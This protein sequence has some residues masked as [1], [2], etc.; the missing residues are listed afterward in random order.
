MGCFVKSRVEYASRQP[1]SAWNAH[2]ESSVFVLPHVSPRDLGDFCLGGLVALLQLAFLFTPPSLLVLY[3]TR[4]I[5]AAIVTLVSAAAP[6]GLT[7]VRGLDLS[8]EGI[9]F[10]RRFG[11][12]KLLRWNQ[13]T[14]IEPVSALEV[15]LRGSFWP[16]PPR[17]CC[18]TF[19]LRGHYRISWKGN[20]CYFPPADPDLF[21]RY[22]TSKISKAGG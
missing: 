12:P 21:E 13:I 19:T 18:A 3:A 16:I 11:S 8:A 5:F 9:R 10:R 1:R 20:Y 22:V 15:V 7:A 2:L 6:F 17:E 4:S 14:S